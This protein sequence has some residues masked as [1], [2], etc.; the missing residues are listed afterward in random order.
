M[1]PM[2]SI[3]MMLFILALGLLHRNA[4][5]AGHTCPITFPA[6]DAYYWQ[7]AV[8]HMPRQPDVSS[9]RLT[10]SLPA[11]RGPV[12]TREFSLTEKTA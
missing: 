8:Q 4:W 11:Y 7:E 9:K 10:A 3:K 5:A 12:R 6:G 2:A 1:Y